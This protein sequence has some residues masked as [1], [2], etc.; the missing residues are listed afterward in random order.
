M[1]ATFVF[2]HSFTSI[3]AEIET[4]F[5]IML[6]QKIVQQLI[7]ESVLKSR[8]FSQTW[9]CNALECNFRPYSESLNTSRVWSCHTN[10]NLKLQN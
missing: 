8:T 10:V 3:L 2:I 1:A 6:L 7:S 9:D 4:V 5:K